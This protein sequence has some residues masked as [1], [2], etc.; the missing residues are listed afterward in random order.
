[1]TNPIAIAKKLR[2]ADLSEIAAIV[3]EAREQLPAA[4]LSQAFGYAAH[5]ICG[6]KGDSKRIN[7]LIAALGDVPAWSDDLAES[8]ENCI[9]NRVRAALASHI[10]AI[11]AGDGNALAGV[12]RA[13]FDAVGSHQQSILLRVI[14]RE[15]SAHAA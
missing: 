15:S 5:Y 10:S 6:D 1:M 11:A 8:T 13:V 12:V 3:A 2:T 7:Q 14:E 9:G 4:E